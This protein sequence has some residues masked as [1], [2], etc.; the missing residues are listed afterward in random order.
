MKISIDSPLYSKK[1]SMEL[2]DMAKN[3]FKKRV[4]VT[5]PRYTDKRT[6]QK[7]PS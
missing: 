7:C 3:K 5:T 1:L 6:K 2:R 4:K